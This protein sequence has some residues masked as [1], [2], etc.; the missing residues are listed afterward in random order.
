[1]EIRNWF[2]KVHRNLPV[3]VELKMY[4]CRIPSKTYLRVP[5][6]SL[7]LVGC[8]SWL[9]FFVSAILGSSCNSLREGGGGVWEDLNVW[10]FET[11][12]SEGV[13]DSKENG[14]LMFSVGT[15]GL[16]SSEQ[17]TTDIEMERP[18]LLLGFNEVKGLPELK[19]GLIGEKG[20]LSCCDSELQEPELCLRSPPR[21]KDSLDHYLWNTISLIKL[22][23]P[24]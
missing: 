17:G 12:V 14:S 8:E 2:R 19:E 22:L 23:T 3:K 20:L 11:C 10:V 18:W 15:V 24:L 4:D 13:L 1:M 21:I 9:L 5:G 7:R 16:W 6:S